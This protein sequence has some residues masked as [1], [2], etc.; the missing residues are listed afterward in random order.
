MPSSSHPLDAVRRRLLLDLARDSILHGLEHGVPIEVD[1]A[2]FPRDLRA[3]RATFVTLESL[4]ELR[5]CLGRLKAARPL[6][7]DIAHN[8]FSA[9]FLDGR[10]PP[11]RE[12]EVEGLGIHLSLLSR[13]EPI[14]FLSEAD[15]AAQ[16]VPGRDGVILEAGASRGTF[17]PSV[18]EAIH[19][20]CEFLRCL[21][22]KAHLPPKGPVDALK[23]FRYTTETIGP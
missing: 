16:L 22:V 23:A 11:V 19:D 14:L 20:P 7:V 13:P 10:F 8:A 6:A 15:L 18:W 21:R 2:S 5:G 12:D 9:A 1:L 4:G 3:L 17:L